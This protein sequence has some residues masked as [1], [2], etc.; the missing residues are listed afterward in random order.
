MRHINVLFLMFIFIASF[1]HAQQ[2]NKA[3][4]PEQFI[5][6]LAANDTTAYKHLFP[7]SGFMFD[8]AGK[9][10]MCGYG[11]ETGPVKNR[12]VIVNGKEKYQLWGIPYRINLKYAPETQ[13]DSLMDATFYLS[14]QGEKMLLEIIRNNKKQEVY[15]IDHDGTC[16][17]KNIRR[18]L[19]DM[20]SKYN[21][22][23]PVAI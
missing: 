9:L 19:L 18:S 16:R 11:A 17:F 4:L 21:T 10:S 3:W 5:E 2:K 20:A 12:K 6:G 1:C 7:V 13:V 23:W 15:F 22:H 8:N 14:V